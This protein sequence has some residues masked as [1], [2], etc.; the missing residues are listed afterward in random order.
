MALTANGIGSGLDINGLVSQLMSVEQRPL[1]ALATKEA[2][3]Q[4]KL[5]AF[6][7]LKSVLAALQTATTGLED[8]AKFS[9]TTTTVGTDAAFTASSDTTATIGS[10]ALEVSQLAKV[11]RVATS[12]TTELAPAAGDLTIDFG[13]VVGGTFTADPART[14]TLAF[15][16]GTIEELRDAINGGDLG[17]KASVINN[18]SVK[19]LVLTGA[20]TGASEAFSLGGTV[21]LS[22]NPDTPGTA[23]DPAY[24]VQAAQDAR[25]TVD[26][27]EIS[28]SSNTVSDAIEGVTL[29][30]TKESPGVTSSLA[31]AKDFGSARNAIGAFVKAYNDVNSTIKGLTAFNAETRQASTLT[32]DSTA[33]GIQGQ[34]RSLAGGALSG[35]GA[36]SR[37]S[38]IGISFK[39]DGNLAVDNTK[40]DAALNDPDT[41]VA[42]F[43]TG[44]G[45]VKGFAETVSAAL[46]GYVGGT[47]LIAGRTDGINASVKSITKQRAAL[48]ARLEQVEKRYRAQFTALDSVIASM[49]QTSN[50]LAQQ[51]ANLPKFNQD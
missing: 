28:R 31:V 51:L 17:V 29:T 48:T 8:A 45:G 47:G 4:S 30:L 18:G 19:Q 2:S 25:L 39:A 43:F 26:G 21:G 1:T 44:T 11:Q 35:L 9:A 10:Y 33:R 14:K 36:T 3:Y 27:I 37:L 20:T 7:Q 13:S 16:G 50:Y 41:N 24:Q 40:L 38:D 42:A 23:G 6:G 46:D 12:S 5:S 22:F 32:G 15:A 49:T 34:L